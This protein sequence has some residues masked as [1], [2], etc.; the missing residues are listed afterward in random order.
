MEIILRF[1]LSVLIISALLLILPGIKTTRFYCA[2]VAAIPITIINMLISPV[3]AASDVLI[4]ALGFGLLIVVLDAVVLWLLG[5]VLR[6]LK[7]DGFGWAF[8]FAIILSLII[9]IVELIFDT[10][11]FE[12]MAS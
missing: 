12:V 3:F 2:I 1:L 8:V 5:L 4:T 9:Y 7:V 10:G 6:G 11:Y